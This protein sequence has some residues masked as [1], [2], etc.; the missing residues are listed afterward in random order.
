L[1]IETIA[2]WG[3]PGGVC[4]LNTSCVKLKT[5]EG[6]LVIVIT[7]F[8]DDIKNCYEISFMGGGARLIFTQSIG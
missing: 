4:A 8:R 1:Q 5:P 7:M 2:R 3:Y 6:K